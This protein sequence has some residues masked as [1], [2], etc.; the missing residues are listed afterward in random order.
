MRPSLP[1][2]RLTRSSSSDSRSF[3]ATT[4]LNA[5]AIFPAIPVQSSGNR[6]V[7]SP[8]LQ[9]VERAEQLFV[10]EL[11]V[12]RQDLTHA[13]SM[14]P[15]GCEPGIACTR[16]ATFAAW[17]CFAFNRLSGNQAAVMKNF[18]GCWHELQRLA[19]R[20]GTG[21]AA[22]RRRF[23][24][25]TYVLPDLAYDLGALEPHISGEVLELHHGKHHKAYVDKANET[26]AKLEEARGK[27]DFSRLAGSRRRSR[28]TSRPRAPL[29]LLEKPL[30]E[31][32]DAPSGELA[33]LIARDFGSFQGF[34]KQLTE[35]ARR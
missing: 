21:I 7:K 28:S 32:G 34:K 18:P 11:L 9:R 5:S 10:V 29:G 24:M 12:D 8:A 22:F 23:A 31:G 20:I 17:K 27:E 30:P 35:V 26:L 2:V 4:S 1:T 19:A 6:T 33:R 3:S 15:W 14:F 16:D 13:L 25:T